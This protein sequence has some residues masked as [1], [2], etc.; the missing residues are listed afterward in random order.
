MDPLY[1]FI[2]LWLFWLLM[3]KAS[4]SDV[5]DLKDEIKEL[6]DEIEKLKK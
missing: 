1:G 4:D 5:S 2:W 3:F 6:K